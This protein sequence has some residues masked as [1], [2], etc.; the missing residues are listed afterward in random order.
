MTTKGQHCGYLLLNN[1][2]EMQPFEK[3]KDDFLHSQVVERVAICK[4][5]TRDI[6]SVGE[7]WDHVIADHRGSRFRELFEN[8]NIYRNN[9]PKTCYFVLWIE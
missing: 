2:D 9:T 6:F 4:S 8:H 3:T 5:G 7:N 1:P